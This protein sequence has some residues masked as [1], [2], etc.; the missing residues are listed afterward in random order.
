MW[1]IVE[2]QWNILFYL[3]ESYSWCN[4]RRPCVKNRKTAFSGTRPRNHGVDFWRLVFESVV[5]GFFIFCNIFK[6]L[7]YVC[8]IVSIF[9]VA[10]L[11]YVPAERMI[12]VIMCCR[13]SATASRYQRT[14][15]KYLHSERH[16][17]TGH[18]S[19]SQ[20]GF[21]TNQRQSKQSFAW[22]ILT[23]RS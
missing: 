5:N 14:D 13:Y 11:V 12:R 16:K 20:V 10:D 8:N 7:T 9:V 3:T 21:W 1:L 19:N 22:I 17:H 6:T 4:C 15:S 23:C 18:Q 2:M